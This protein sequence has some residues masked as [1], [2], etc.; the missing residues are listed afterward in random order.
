M[1]SKILDF[2]KKDNLIPDNSKIIVGLSGGPDSVFLLY[3]LQELQKNLKFDLI[4]AHLDHQW[5]ENSY[6]DLEFCKNLCEQLNIPFF[7]AKAKDL[8]LSIKYTGSKEELGRT[9]RRFFLEKTA[10][11][12]NANLIALAHHLQD[13]EETFL[14]RLIRGTTLSGLISMKSKDAIYIRPLLETNKKDILN[15]L[16]QNNIK[17]IIDPSNQ[18]PEFLRNRIRNTVIPRLQECDSRFDD[19]FLKTLHKLQ[20]TELFLQKLIEQKFTD[21]TINQDNN[22]TLDLKKF[23]EQDLFMQKKLIYYWIYKNQV[24]FELTEKFLEE[25]LRFLQNNKSST[26]K[27]HHEWQIQKIKNQAK[28]LSKL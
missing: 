9:M 18:S 7:S 16:N 21:V 8:N 12:Q 20:D 24:K 17:F 14:I 15:Y 23:F 19:N 5:R 2:I 13:Q 3:Y 22:Y 27:I 10:K 28:I 26:H 11:E 1:I 4:A 6:L 25:I